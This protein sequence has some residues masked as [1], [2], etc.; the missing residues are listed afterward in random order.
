MGNVRAIDTE[1][2][3]DV[4]IE[5]AD[6]SG[7]EDKDT[8]LPVRIL[9]IQGYYIDAAGDKRTAKM[10]LWFNK[11][12]RETI[13]SRGRNA[14]KTVWDMQIENLHELGLPRPFS[15]AAVDQLVGKQARFV[16]ESDPKW[17]LRVRYMNKAGGRVMAAEEVTSAFKVLEGSIAEPVTPGYPAAA[18]AGENL[19]GNT[20]STDNEIPF[21]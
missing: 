6:W 17:G 2:S 5:A 8:G 13:I 10:E 15:P 11:R 21:N 12:S 7:Y 16:I 14:G 19:F 3:Y 1:G 18:P 9:T 4:T 20:A